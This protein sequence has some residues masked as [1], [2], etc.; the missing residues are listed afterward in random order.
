MEALKQVFLA[1][2]SD[3]NPILVFPR[4]IIVFVVAVL[5]VRW[6]KKRFI[7]Q[8]TAIDLVMAIIFGSVLSR[9]INGGA[10]LLSTLVAGLSLVL[11]QRLAAH[12]SARSKRFA[13]FVKGTTQI[14][15]RDGVVDYKEMLNHDVT[16]EDLK[17][18]M[19]VHALTDDLDKIKVAVF[20]R[21]GHVGF[22]KKEES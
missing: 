11:L 10:T 1:K 14:L 9:A 19:R 21:S 20:E 18:E 5:Y 22:V 8:A 7:A 6:S 17:E 15:V 3:L 4:T 2:G 13:N 16:E 12:Q